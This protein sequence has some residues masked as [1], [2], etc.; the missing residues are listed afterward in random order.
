MIIELVVGV[1][2]IMEIRI[3]EN[4]IAEEIIKNLK[5]HNLIGEKQNVTVIY[6]AE[7]QDILYTVAEVAK[8]I[9]TNPA[10]VYELIKKGLLPALKL[11]GYK[12]RRTSLLE[13]LEKY[14]G[15][16]VSDPLN[17]KPVVKEEND[18]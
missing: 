9:K 6:N 16:D 5:R 4:Q 8:L 10:Y 7:S 12:I 15:Y 13:F 2:K 1:I 3:D 17:I 18:W 11:R 14:E